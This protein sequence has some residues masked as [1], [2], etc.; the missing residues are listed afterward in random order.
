MVLP[1]T[2]PLS[3]S[4][5][6]IEL[7]RGAGTTISLGEAEVRALA[8]V[9]SGPISKASLRGKSAQ[10]VHTIAAHQLHLNLRSYLL[11][12]GWDG[13]NESTAEPSGCAPG[14]AELRV[15]SDE[16]QRDNADVRGHAQGQRSIQA[17]RRSNPDI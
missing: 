6:N 12:V 15:V 14:S 17:D 2:G 5:V 13:T 9:G 4:Q 3:L 11:G 10:F 16:H 7:G 8:G 1:L